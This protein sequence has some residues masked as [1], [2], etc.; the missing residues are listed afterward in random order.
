[1]DTHQEVL[2]YL[3]KHHVM[4]IATLGAEGAAA[5][6]VFYVNRGTNLYFLSSPH[7]RHCRNFMVDARVA[8]TIHEDY[9]DWSA[10]KGIQIDALARELDGQEKEDAKRLYGEKFPGVLGDRPVFAALAEALRKVR[11]YELAAQRIRFI[12][13]QR[14]FGHKEEWSVADFLA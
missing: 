7:S 2:D 6:A 12:N 1:M 4:T 3:C 8:L 9:S 11:W 5:A 13:N 10:I 14:G